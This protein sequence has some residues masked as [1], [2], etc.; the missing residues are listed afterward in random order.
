MKHLSRLV[1]GAVRV[2]ACLEQG[3]A[4]VVHCSD[5]WDR[6]AQLSALSQII[7]D[8]HY[9]TFDGFQ[10][11]VEKEWLSFGHMF[12]NRNHS[13]N[14]AYES[15]ASSPIFL[16]WLD[17]VFQ[18]HR[19]N[20][21]SFE[22]SEGYLQ[23]LAK[24]CYSGW[25][26]TFNFDNERQCRLGYGFELCSVWA[27]LDR[28]KLRNILYL[29]PAPSSSTAQSSDFG[30]GR[31]VDILGVCSSERRLR[32]ILFPDTRSPRLRR[33]KTESEGSPRDGDR[34]GRDGGGKGNKGATRG[35][36]GGDDG[37]TGRGG[38]SRPPPSTRRGHLQK[39]NSVRSQL[40]PK[41]LELQPKLD[42]GFSTDY[43]QP[44]DS[45]DDEGTWESGREPALT[46]S[47]GATPENKDQRASRYSH[48]FF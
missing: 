14:Q 44:D 18:I 25:F 15:G 36:R 29:P 3:Q 17:A 12:R 35:A 20:P 21:T 40:P 16:Q 41:F 28:D 47:R 32:A 19:Q 37:R 5:G 9:R 38:S 10:A 13:T 46:P 4:C 39:T 24:H 26:G 22:F 34:D 11:L 1:R 43:N 33:S 27:Y 30:G 2:S 45:S 31:D 8:P 6:T 42:A 23:L 48:H 7:M